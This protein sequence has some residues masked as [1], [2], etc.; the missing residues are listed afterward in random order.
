MEIDRQTVDHVAKL[1]RLYLDEQSTEDLR[2]DLSQIVGYVAK[3]RELDTANVEQ[4]AH[5]LPLRNVLRE[6]TVKES[7][8]REDVLANTSHK[9]NGFFEVPKIFD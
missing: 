9:K 8:D 6:D 7:M 2:G 1:A 3:L 5:V 4:T